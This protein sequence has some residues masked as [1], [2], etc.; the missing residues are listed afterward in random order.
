ME[1]SLEK[2]ALGG[3]G[4]R[5]AVGILSPLNRL[6]EG[7]ERPTKILDPNAQPFLIHYHHLSV[8]W[9]RPLTPPYMGR[10]LQMRELRP[11]EVQDCGW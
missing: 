3:P 10:I 5:G 11:S 4:A 1:L 8:G 9:P 6:R 2:E 7:R